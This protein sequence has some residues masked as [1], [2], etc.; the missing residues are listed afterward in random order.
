MVVTSYEG[1]PHVVGF[2]LIPFVKV[3][4]VLGTLYPNPNLER[5]TNSEEA[6][7]YLQN[8]E[9]QLWNIQRAFDVSMVE[10]YGSTRTRSGGRLVAVI[11]LDWNGFSHKAMVRPAAEETRNRAIV[12]ALKKHIAIPASEV[13]NDVFALFRNIPSYEIGG[14]VKFDSVSKFVVS[15]L[16]RL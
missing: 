9:E 3:G 12:Q 13:D 11:Y 1:T 10:C 5:L 4:T 16:L 8:S 6:I 15:D 7:P 2:P 14:G